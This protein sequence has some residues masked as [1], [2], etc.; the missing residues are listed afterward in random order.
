MALGEYLKEN[1][2]LRQLKL[3][4]NKITDEGAKAL[5][6]ALYKNNSIEVLHL[7]Q[8][9][10]TEKSIDVFLELFKAKRTIRT[11]FFNLN[12]I[13]LRNAKSKVADIMAL[14]VNISL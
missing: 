3:V 9:L 5:A 10:L 1:N 2:K 13:K 12:S 14:G 8:N 11:I 6:Q 4:K 7:S